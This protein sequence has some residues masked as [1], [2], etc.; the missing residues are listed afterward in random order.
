[1]GSGSKRKGNDTLIINRPRPEGTATGGG[2]SG[3]EDIN[4]V[5]PPAF[6]VGI[7]PPRP[8]PDGTPVTV[9][10]QELYIHGDRVGKLTSKNEEVLTRC[11]DHGI[12]YAA[13]VVN[14]RGK[15]YAHFSQV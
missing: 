2:S 1:M 3:G 13:A 15:A 5:C 10:G 8:I 6:D 7:K 9:K 4:R 12:G 11:A 14:R